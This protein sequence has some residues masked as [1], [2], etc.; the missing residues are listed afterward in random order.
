MLQQTGQVLTQAK[1]LIEQ[2]QLQLRSLDKASRRELTTKVNLYKSS[3]KGLEDDYE[4]ARQAE[5][6]SNLLG[7]PGGDGISLVSR[8]Q[9]G[10]MQNATE[11]ARAQN[12]VLQNAIQTVADT[13][14][15]AD[16][17]ADELGRNREKIE[18]AHRRVK[19]VDSLT[20]NARR[21]IR[22]MADRD[23]RSKMMI[24]AV[25]CCVFT[26]MLIGAGYILFGGGESPAPA[27]N[28]IPTESPT[29]MPTTAAPTVAP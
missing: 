3:L 22:S 5:E 13:E 14:E 24:Y 11:R 18:S 8:E 4:R 2:M 12:D 26:S 9:R 20:G 7:D 29:F 10:R 6:R 27:P 1:Q 21:I 16:S 25:L 23:K 28:P 15:V 19:E 17:I